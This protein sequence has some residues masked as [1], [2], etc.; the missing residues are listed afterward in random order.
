M[1]H[2]CDKTTRWCSCHI[3]GANRRQSARATSGK[4]QVDRPRAQLDGKNLHLPQVFWQCLGSDGIGQEPTNS[5][6][7][8]A[9]CHL[10]VCPT[11]GFSASCQCLILTN[12]SESLAG[13]YPVSRSV[14]ER[15]PSGACLSAA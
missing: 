9:R 15:A 10:P 3:L 14:S 6:G 1:P 11:C 5:V 4:A 12:L 8:T 7:S 2:K 13:R